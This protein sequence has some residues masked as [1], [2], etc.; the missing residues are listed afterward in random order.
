M[1]KALLGGLAV[2]TIWGAATAAGQTRDKKLPT[3]DADKPWSFVSPK[4][5]V[6]PNPLDKNWVRNPID[7]FILAALEKQAIKPAAEADRITL[8]RRL[9]FDLTGLPPTPDEVA[10]L[11]SDK[12]DDAYERGV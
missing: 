9:T 5:P 8:I 2:L 12:S 1:R 6:P 7:A 11:L 10:A 4:R 3:S